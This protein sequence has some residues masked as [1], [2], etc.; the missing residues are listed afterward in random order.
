[1]IRIALI[2]LFAAYALSSGMA[3]ALNETPGAEANNTGVRESAID[4]RRDSA[5]NSTDPHRSVKEGGRAMNQKKRS[6]PNVGDAG[7]VTKGQAETPQK[8]KSR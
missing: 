4:A 1:M 5:V 3:F 8:P 7:M 2:S 6:K